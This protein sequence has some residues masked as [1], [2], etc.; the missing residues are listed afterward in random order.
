MKE[1]LIKNED[2][3]SCYCGA[4]LKNAKW[5]PEFSSHLFYR[6]LK[7]S[8]G[9]KNRVKMDWS[10]SGHDRWQPTGAEKSTPDVFEDMVKKEHTKVEKH[11]GSGH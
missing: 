11:E 4:D 1:H 8:C 2:I 5:E 6:T 9:R 7:C 3:Q 10:G